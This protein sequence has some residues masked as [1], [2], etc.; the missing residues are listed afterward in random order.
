M[1]FNKKKFKKIFFTVAIVSILC[2]IGTIFCFAEDVN[3]AD[4]SGV[5]QEIVSLLVSGIGEFGSG[6]ANGIGSYMNDLFISPSGGL[7]TT[8]G[9]IVIFA[10]ISLTCGITALVW[11]FITT[12]GARK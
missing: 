9:I 6:L 10:A 8:G 3:T 2:L 1:K 12:L 7:S 11:N 4:L 5:L